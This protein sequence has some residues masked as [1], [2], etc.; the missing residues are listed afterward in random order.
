MTDIAIS[1][2]VAQRRQGILRALDD[3][4]ALLGGRPPDA[5]VLAAV[6]ERL[7]QLAAHKEWFNHE[8]FPPPAE[9]EGVGAS[10]R[11]RLNPEDGGAGPA[12]YLNAINPGKTTLPHNHTTWA[13]IVAVDGEE[14]NRI[15]RRTDDGRDP[16][17]ATLAL[18]R[19]QTVRPGSPIAFL[20]ED[21]HSIHGVGQRPTLHFHLYGRPLETLTGRIGIDL[22][23]GE[24]VNYNATQFRPS[25]TD[26]AR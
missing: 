6:A 4:R 19:E 1:P 25:Q 8:Q 5:A 3:I 7:G 16:V 10:S 14:E 18:V 22:V 26:P 12:L 17:R 2:L 11:Y 23:S 21:I 20:A 9:T 13:V 24:V 15:Y